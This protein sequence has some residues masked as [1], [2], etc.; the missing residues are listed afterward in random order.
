MTSVALRLAAQMRLART[1]GAG[2]PG[3]T[4]RRVGWGCEDSL[5]PRG[6]LRGNVGTVGASWLAP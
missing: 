4:L 1:G 3:T 5:P 6:P 2:F